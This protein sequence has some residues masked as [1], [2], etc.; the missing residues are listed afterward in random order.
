[1][2]D[3]DAVADAPIVDVIGLHCAAQP[4]LSMGMLTGIVCL[5]SICVWTCSQAWKVAQVHAQRR[6]KI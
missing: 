1:L 5:F 4:Q 2:A 3:L 6:S